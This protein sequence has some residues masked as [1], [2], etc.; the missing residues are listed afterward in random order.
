MK[1]TPNHSN[2]VRQSDDGS[3][4]CGDLSTDPSIC[5]K[6][7]TSAVLSIVP[8]TFEH[9]SNIREMF[10]EV[11]VAG[12]TIPED[13]TLT[14][15][16]IDAIW[17][18]NGISPFVALYGGEV[19][20]AHR[21]NP[22]YAGPGSHVANATYVTHTAYRGKGIGRRLVEHSLGEAKRQGYKAMQYNF[23][24]STN[25]AAVRLYK[26]LGFQILAT[27]PQ[28]FLHPTLGYVDVH[29]MHTFLSTD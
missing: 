21:L 11:L 9:S 26:S 15:T 19:V 17:F 16:E 7:W 6:V 22:N 18:G 14:D 27:L 10:R 1:T 25:E 4:R 29:V 2:T 13:D 28:A 8:A 5:C 23:V 24:V 12:D 3:A 20:G